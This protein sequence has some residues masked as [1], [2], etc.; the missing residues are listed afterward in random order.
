MTGIR[1]AQIH[2]LGIA[3]DFLP[4]SNEEQITFENRPNMFPTWSNDGRE[5]I[6]STGASR[7]ATSLHRMSVFPPGEP[8]RLPFVG[9]GGLFPAISRNGNKLAYAQLSGSAEDIWRVELDIP[10]GQPGSPYRFIAST[11]ADRQPVYS[12]DGARI[13]FQSVRSGTPEVWVCEADGTNEFQLTDAGGWD[14]AWSPSG[15]KIAFRSDQQ[16][17]ADLFV[18]G[19]NGAGLSRLT[20][21][22]AHDGE[23]RWSIDGKWIFFS[24][25]RGGEWQ[26]WKV[27]AGGGNPVL[28][29]RPRHWSESWD[30][31]SVYHLEEG[32]LWSIPLEGG[33]RIRIASS[34]SGITTF[35]TAEAG[36]YFT[37]SQKL[38][39]Y[40]F[41]S[42]QTRTIASLG[43]E[44]TQLAA[45][46]DGKSILYAR[47][48]ERQ[49]RSDLMLIEHLR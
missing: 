6:F 7:I 39:F 24:S 48:G 17:N 23:P 8:E 41:S 44:P 37:T 30:G 18:V 32:L 45:S 40:D 46:P 20:E 29:R 47:R 11:A 49:S 42:G 36:I 35:A 14:P 5:L 16:G 38:Q 1:N 13:A 33:S 25:R 34:H 22:S 10:G 4:S 28:T 26:V 19:A 27:P 9:V 15:D 12:P 31:T 3:E 21:N 43:G 2:L